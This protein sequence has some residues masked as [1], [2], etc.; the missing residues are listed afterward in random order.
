MEKRPRYY[1]NF[2]IEFGK[3]PFLPYFCTYPA[4]RVFCIH[5]LW[6]FFYQIPDDSNN[7]H[8]LYFCVGSRSFTKSFDQRK[9]FETFCIDKRHSIF[10]VKIF[11]MKDNFF[12]ILVSTYVSRIWIGIKKNSNGF[13]NTGNKT[14]LCWFL[15]YIIFIFKKNHSH[16][17]RKTF[18]KV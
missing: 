8:L 5:I 11:V 14:I 17:F 12:A 18:R 6:F 15:Y 7:Q 13:L 16:I 2:S 4:W 10:T 9:I 3:I 1:T